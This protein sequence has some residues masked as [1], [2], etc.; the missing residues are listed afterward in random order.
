MDRKS[1][2]SIRERVFHNFNRIKE[3]LCQRKY[4][5]H[6]HTPKLLVPYSVIVHGISEDNTENDVISC[7]TTHHVFMVDILDADCA[8]E[9]KR[10]SR[11]ART[12]DI[13]M[14]YTHDLVLNC[15]GMVPENRGCEVVY[16]ADVLSADRCV[17]SVLY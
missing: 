17:K 11:L 14:L 13:D 16:L 10:L 8:C 9:D 12:T 5:F 7:L 4:K 3:M 15:K 6:P 2:I 1:V